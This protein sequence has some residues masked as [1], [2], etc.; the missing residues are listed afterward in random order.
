MSKRMLIVL[1]ALLLAM[2]SFCCTANAERTVPL[3]DLIVLEEDN[4][5]LIPQEDGTLQVHKLN[6]SASADEHVSFL[7]ETD[8]RTV[9]SYDPQTRSLVYKDG[10]AIN[11]NYPWRKWNHVQRLIGLQPMVCLTPE[12]RLLP[13]A[14]DVAVPDWSGLTDAWCL[15]GETYDEESDTS[16]PWTGL[17]GLTAEGKMLTTG[18]P[19]KMSQEIAKWKNIS[20][21]YQYSQVMVAID[22]QGRVY[23]AT[24]YE[25]SMS[26]DVTELFGGPGVKE[27]I[28]RGNLCASLK[29]D[30]TVFLVEDN[31]EEGYLESL[32]I[33]ENYDAVKSWTDVAEIRILSVEE[34]GEEDGYTYTTH[35]YAIVGVT[36]DGQLLADGVRAASSEWAD[37]L[38]AAEEEPVQAY[39][40]EDYIR[41]ASYRT[42]LAFSTR[43]A[44]M[45]DHE[46]FLQNTG[47][48]NGS[49]WF[50]G[51]DEWHDLV[52]IA[53]TFSHIVGL[54]ADG[55]VVADGL[56]NSNQC[57]VDSWWNITEVAAG[58]LFTVGLTEYGMVAYAGTT[59]K[60]A[61]LAKYWSNI[62]AIDACDDHVV[63]LRAD[64]T[65]LSTAAEYGRGFTEVLSWS[66]LV[67]IAAGE[68]NSAA[69]ILVDGTVVA[70]RNVPFHQP[71]D[72]VN[73]ADI[74]FSGEVLYGLRSDGTVVAS[75]P[76][77]AAEVAQWTDVIQIDGC[78]DVLLGMKTDG[79]LLWAGWPEYADEEIPETLAGWNFYGDED[80]REAP[81]FYDIYAVRDLVYDDLVLTNVAAPAAV[82]DGFVVAV[83]RSGKLFLTEGAPESL[84]AAAPE[85]VSAVSAYGRQVLVT[86]KD[87]SRVLYNDAGEQPLEMAAKAA[88]GGAHLLTIREEGEEWNN[89]V[90]ACGANDF[91]QCEFAGAAAVTDIAA[92]G[93]HSVAVIGGRY[94][95]A[96]GENTY[97]QCDVGHWEAVNQVSAGERHTLGLTQ[98]GR[99]LAAGDNTHGQC[100]VSDW[101]G[102][103]KMIAA[104]D[105]FSAGM[106]AEGR[107]LLAGEL[108]AALQQALSWERIVFIAA[109]A[110]ALVGVD[111]SGRLYSTASDVSAAAKIHTAD[112]DIPDAFY[113]DVTVD[114][115]YDTLAVGA[116]GCIALC[117]DG[118]VIRNEIRYNP[119]YD[120]VEDYGEY[121]EE[122][123]IGDTLTT[124]DKPI[125]MVCAVRDGAVLYEDGTVQASSYFPEAAQWQNVVMISGTKKLLGALTA[126]GRV[127]L[128]G[129]VDAAVAAQVASWPPVLC[130]AV[131]DKHVTGVTPDGYMISSDPRD[132]YDSNVWYDI[133]S[134]GDGV[135]VRSDGTTTGGMAD[136]RRVIAQ[137]Y[138]NRQWL[139]VYEDGATSLE[140]PGMAFPIVQLEVFGDCFIL[141]QQ[142]GTILL[143]GSKGEGV[144]DIHLWKIALP[145]GVEKIQQEEEALP[146]GVPGTAT[147][148]P[149]S[150]LYIGGN[151]LLAVLPDGHVLE[152]SAD[153]WEYDESTR[154]WE[155]VETRQTI[156]DENVW[157]D[158]VEIVGGLGLRTDGLV[159]SHDFRG[160]AVIVEG[161]ANVR[162]LVMNGYGAILA[163]GAFISSQDNERTQAA[164]AWTDLVDV[165]YVANGIVG[166][167]SD[168]TV[169]SYGLGDT[170][171]EMI[172]SWRN[173]IEIAVYEEDYDGHLAG[174]TTSGEVLLTNAVPGDPPAVTQ[175]VRHILPSDG[176]VMVLFEDGT[177]GEATFSWFY[178]NELGGDV[179][180]AVANNYLAVALKADG[181]LA[182]T[183]TGDW[184]TDGFH[185][186]YYEWSID[187]IN[188]DTLEGLIVK[189]EP[190]E[191]PKEQSATVGVIGTA[192]I[193]PYNRLRL[194]DTTLRIILPDGHVLQLAD[195][196][197]VDAES[198]EWIYA[199]CQQTILPEDIWYDIVE[200]VGSYGLRRDGTVALRETETFYSVMSEWRNVKKLVCG[201]VQAIM[202][203][204]TYVTIGS[205][206]N[207]FIQRTSSWTDVVDVQYVGHD[208]GTVGLKSDGTLIIELLDARIAADVGQWRNIVEIAPFR[209]SHGNDQLAGLTTDGKVLLSGA[210]TDD[211][212]A[213]SKS[214]AHL[215]PDTYGT[216]VYALYQDETVGGLTSRC[217]DLLSFDNK[218]IVEFVSNG[219]CA[220]GVRGDGWLVY[221]VDEDAEEAEYYPNYAAWN[222]DAIN[223]NTLEG[224]IVK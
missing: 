195:K 98:D 115:V 111:A 1:A 194:T 38:G 20:K 114:M 210:K 183:V 62:M 91:G 188:I 97:G 6:S 122:Y 101:A 175:P 224:V 185:P 22:R 209:D 132:T 75:D 138:A 108:T 205:E 121:Y 196:Y 70:T 143:S 16:L 12:G 197:E 219:F 207:T 40:T 123:A 222:L 23:A 8:W 211:P 208:G 49:A 176:A 19:E 4:L 48:V 113:A 192:T 161:W 81:F 168:G 73:L 177:V 53:G 31:Y 174:L 46:G 79:S 50:G 201:G 57:D 131:G 25:G 24:P 223:I 137:G 165:Q 26:G 212:P 216:A 202:E 34:E 179:V 29:E 118:S 144:K 83:L 28:F 67:D 52:S 13:A 66:H 41:R 90:Y 220:I 105:R 134:F 172:A 55:T 68:N 184:A 77:A 2:G 21:A 85:K 76:D 86:F 156:L 37:I 157:Y 167:R 95:A 142:D 139:S 145:R 87:G 71:D 64:G 218:D 60:S 159:V 124:L 152:K 72:F 203:D 30:G 32:F 65:A 136:G 146:E 169:V 10:T 125:A 182:Y 160:N 7:L 27:I 59:E 187:T 200:N 129:D 80:E 93:H 162:K 69:G 155:V 99:V 153:K 100:D 112:I 9:S 3:S 158:I 110:D 126:D 58:D 15:T 221:V 43:Y 170:L 82:G 119:Y 54:R 171:A 217:M 78:G 133:V 215:C 35:H 147:F 33:A 44:A 151:S 116:Y 166:L 102:M 148:R 193:R 214:V 5:V 128:S 181:S 36:R 42:G 141:Q 84:K 56:N 92:G 74:A 180:E 199:G 198:D 88:V 47:E 178:F 104:G 120:S 154:K 94:L 61:H 213:T 204:G 164:S 149:Y 135:A 189:P 51:Y 206:G 103:V 190:R 163:D 39:E 18:L 45:I 150:R 11:S 63:G 186:N 117:E 96:A 109:N 127:H 107:V 140:I 89:T 14:G 130:F 106:T 17:V 173:V 191:V